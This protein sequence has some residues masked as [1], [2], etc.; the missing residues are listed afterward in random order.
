VVPDVHIQGECEGEFD[1]FFRSARPD[2]I[3][4]AYLLV[5]DFEIAQELTQETLTRAWSHWPTIRTY[6]NPAAWARRVLHN[7][8]LDHLRRA[9]RSQGR[10][11]GRRVDDAVGVDS[12]RLPVLDALATLPPKER[13]ALVLYEVVG[14][15]VAQVGKEM[16]VSTGTVKSWLSRA[17]AR[18]IRELGLDPSPTGGRGANR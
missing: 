8:A 9:R 14:L 2:L 10:E 13:R 1:E 11:R 3:G 12:D 15:S 7:L 18:F 6:E 4:Q 16:N 17:R 5:G